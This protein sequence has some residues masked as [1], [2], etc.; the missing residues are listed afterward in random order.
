MI[1]VRVRRDVDQSPEEVFTD[2]ADWT[3]NPTWQKGM[4]SC[5]WTSEPPLRVGSTYDQ[6]ARANP[7]AR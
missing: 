5:T 4:V 6:A 1:E 3:N 2:W 7:T